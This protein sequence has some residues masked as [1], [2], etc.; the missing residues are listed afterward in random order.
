MTPAHLRA[1][2]PLAP[3]QPQSMEFVIKL[4]EAQTIGG[5]T[6]AAPGAGATAPTMLLQPTAESVV[7][8]GTATFSS[9]ATGD[10]FPTVQWQSSPDG[11]TWSDIGGATSV[12]YTT[13]VLALGDTGTQYRAVFTN[14]AGAV[15]SSAVTLTVTAATTP[16]LTTGFVLPGVEV[17]VTVEA[18]PALTPP[19]FTLLTH[20]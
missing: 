18:L 11:T 15:T 16:S 19:A 1:L 13:P 10:P 12:S 20:I 9:V 3:V 17:Y 8:G 5:T 2:Q 4:Y 14:T 7:E 6:V